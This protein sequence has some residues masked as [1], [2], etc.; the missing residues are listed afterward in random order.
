MKRNHWIARGLLAVS[1]LAGANL[2]AQQLY[3]RGSFNGWEKEELKMFK[4]GEKKDIEL[5]KHP[6]MNKLFI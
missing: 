2:T 3:L 5:S 4:F 6:L 1:L